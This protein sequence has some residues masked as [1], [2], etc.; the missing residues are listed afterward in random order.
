MIVIT[1]QEK[2][3][4]LNLYEQDSGFTRYLDRQYQ[5]EKGTQEVKQM[6]MDAAQMVKNLRQQSPFLFDTIV[7]LGLFAVPYVGPYLSAGYGTAIA[8]KDINDGR[9]V[10]GIIGLITSPLGLL[11][12]MKVLK[13]FDVVEDKIIKMLQEINKTGLPVLISQGQQKFLEWGYKTFSTNFDKFMKMVG[14]KKKMEQLIKEIASDL[15]NKTQ[16]TTSK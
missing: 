8:I 7:G 3:H 13:I 5:T 14:D 16:T 9:Y 2:R 11:R 1:E 10:Q 4:I 12:A 6:Y 15:K